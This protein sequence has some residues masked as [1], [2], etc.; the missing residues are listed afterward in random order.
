MKTPLE[1]VCEQV[2][3]IEKGIDRDRAII[4]RDRFMSVRYEELVKKP[5]RIMHN[6]RDFYRK[7]ST[8]DDLVVRHDI[9]SSFSDSNS[10][11]KVD[12]EYKAI[13]AYFS[14]LRNEG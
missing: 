9:P 7:N 5:L 4:G 2:Y 1:Q 11:R 14:H 6:L 10:T 13:E 3:D 8:G 12:S